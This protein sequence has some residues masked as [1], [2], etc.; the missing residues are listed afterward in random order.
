MS[1]AW[2]AGTACE[3]LHGGQWYRGVARGIEHDCLVLAEVR[4]K[5]HTTAVALNAVAEVV[6]AKGTHLKWSEADGRKVMGTSPAQAARPTPTAAGKPG[7][8]TVELAPGA[9]GRSQ[10]SM[11]L[12]HPDLLLSTVLRDTPNPEA[13]AQLLR[14]TLALANQCTVEATEVVATEVEASLDGSDVV[15]L[16]VITVEAASPTRPTKRRR[17]GTVGMTAEEAIAQAEYEGLKLVTSAT[18]VSGYHA[19]TIDRRRHGDVPFRAYA[20][21]KT[22]GSYLGAFATAEEAAL[23][24]A[25]S[26]GN[27]TARLILGK[28][29]HKNSHVALRR[30]SCATVVC[31]RAGCAALVHLHS[32]RRRARAEGRASFAAGD[33]CAGPSCSLNWRRSQFAAAQRRM[34]AALVAAERFLAPWPTCCDDGDLRYFPTAAAEAA[35]EAALA[36]L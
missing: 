20:G 6:T 16:D 22:K 25:R 3:F 1:S 35:A 11:S 2:P 30:E 29:Q 19:V 4:A 5:G 17:S 14:D 27:T 18:S 36:A 21:A 10:A 31:C 15:T 34:A 33:G 12:T 24:H 23:A 8:R 28:G 26:T 32:A 13:A 7:K 9:A